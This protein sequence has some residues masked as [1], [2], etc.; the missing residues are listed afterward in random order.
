MVTIFGSARLKQDD[1]YARKAQMLGQLCVS[2]GISVLTGGG[3]G[4]MAAA[5]YGAKMIQS[6]KAKSLGIGVTSLHEKKNEFVSEYFELNYLFARK[7]LLTRFSSAFIVFPGGLGT[8][9]ELA[10]VLILI[11]LKQHK[12][13]PVIL[14][15]TEFWNP[16]VEWMKREMLVHETIEKSAFEL[17]VVTDNIEHAFSLICRNCAITDKRTEEAG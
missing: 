11:K 10:E 8:L 12:K 14:I 4:I 6:A 17:F 16:F 5:N 3:P 9:D 15:G 1:P 2:K 13:V 7:W